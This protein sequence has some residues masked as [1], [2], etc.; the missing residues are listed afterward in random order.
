MVFSL[1][2]SYQEWTKYTRFKGL[3]VLLTNTPVV[4]LLVITFNPQYAVNALLPII[5]FGY[6]EMFLR[7]KNDSYEQD[8]ENRSQTSIY[9]MVAIIFVQCL[10]VLGNVLY[11]PGVDLAPPNSFVYSKVWMG[12]TMA[13]AMSGVLWNYALY[14]LHGFFTRNLKIGE[15]HVLYRDGLRQYVRHLGY[16]AVLLQAVATSLALTRKPVL[17]LAVCLILLVTYAYRIR[18]EENM[19]TQE[20]GDEYAQYMKGS[21]DILPFINL[22]EKI[23]YLM[24]T[25]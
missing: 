3:S 24:N 15:G 18:D 12:A 10:V 17:A 11:I 14:S 19:L 25:E 13:Q 2:P 20:F 4:L 21:G 8:E 22:T 9:I 1:T 7:P 6:A 16:S 23:L 5:S